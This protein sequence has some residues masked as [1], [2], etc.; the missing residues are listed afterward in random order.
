MRYPGR[1]WT[2]VN[3]DLYVLY[4]GD[5]IHAHS[6]HFLLSKTQQNRSD[7]MLNMF[8]HVSCHGPLFWPSGSS[9]RSQVSLAS[10]IQRVLGAATGPGWGKMCSCSFTLS[11]LAHLILWSRGQ[12]TGNAYGWHSRESFRLLELLKWCWVETGDMCWKGCCVRASFPPAN[13]YGFPESRTT[14]DLDPM[15]C[16]HVFLFWSVMHR[17]G[18]GVRWPQQLLR[19]DSVQ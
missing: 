9:I 1:R 5:K 10:G 18:N 11:C 17:G 3:F 2:A 15:L 4:R 8:V 7:N 6:S 12:A 13:S 14:I 19:Q 16:E